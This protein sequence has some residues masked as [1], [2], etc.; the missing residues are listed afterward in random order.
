VATVSSALLRWIIRKPTTTIG[1][2][3]TRAKPA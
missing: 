2:A 1:T 3:P